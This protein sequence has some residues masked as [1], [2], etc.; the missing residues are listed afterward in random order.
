MKPELKRC[1]NSRVSSKLSDLV[2]LWSLQETEMRAKICWCLTDLKSTGC[3]HHSQGKITRYV[4]NKGERDRS[5]G[6][7]REDSIVGGEGDLSVHHPVGRSI[8]VTHTSNVQIHHQKLAH[9]LQCAHKSMLAVLCFWASEHNRIDNWICR[10]V[11]TFPEQ[12]LTTREISVQSDTR[13]HRR[14]MT[15]ILL[16]YRPCRLVY[17]FLSTNVLTFG[18][19]MQRRSL[20]HGK[21][22]STIPVVPSSLVEDLSADFYCCVWISDVELSFSCCLY[23]FVIVFCLLFFLFVPSFASFLLHGMLPSITVYL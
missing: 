15:Y 19:F 1:G 7:S 22:Q 2:V 14:N 5:N 8:R 13:P 9:I 20:T 3:L 21:A 11:F 23:V 6:D 12:K 16:L 4:T 18:P 17:L 10:G